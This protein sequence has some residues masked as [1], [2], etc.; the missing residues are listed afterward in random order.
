MR[1]KFLVPI[2][3]LLILICWSDAA[4]ACSE[5]AF[6]S[7]EDAFLKSQT[8]FA[9]IAETANETGTLF[10]VVEWYKTPDETFEKSSRVL[11]KSVVGEG[12]ITGE[13]YIVHGTV[14]SGTTAVLPVVENR[15][16]WGIIRPSIE[17]RI[18]NLE[19]WEKLPEETR[20]NKH[21]IVFIG[22]V[23]QAKHSETKCERPY[24]DQE[25]KVI[26]SEIEFEIIRIFQNK[27]LKNKL[28]ATDKISI[29]I[30][31][32]GMGYEVGKTYLVF[33]DE[34]YDR[35]TKKRVLWSS[36]FP[37]NTIFNLDEKNFLREMSRKLLANPK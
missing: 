25:S 5:C 4:R 2:L 14:S 29:H 7:R 11:V 36:C 10:K 28:P 24:P 30:S 21:D 27:S 16:C 19:K 12:Y 34:S 13:E 15:E 37:P 17:N 9:G 35:Q 31:D 8:V 6:Y 18:A 3:S 32:C 1:L 33:S 23:T 20:E 26:A 22:Q